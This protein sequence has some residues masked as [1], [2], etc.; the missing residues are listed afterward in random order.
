MGD[1]RTITEWEI[2]RLE[3][4]DTGDFDLTE[5]EFSFISRLADNYSTYGAD[6]FCSEKQAAWLHSI[7]E[8]YCKDNNMQGKVRGLPK[9]KTWED[10]KDEH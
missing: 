7:Y 8:K 10:M 3:E 2:E 6:C 4:L 9:V 5:G 1:G